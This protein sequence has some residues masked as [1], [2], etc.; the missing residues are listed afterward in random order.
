MVMRYPTRE[1][2]SDSSSLSSADQ[3]TASAARAPGWL[4][5]PGARSMCERPKTPEGSCPV[6]RGL[7]I[8]EHFSL[9]C[10]RA[11]R[12]RGY[13][14]SRRAPG[15]LAGRPPEAVTLEIVCA[16]R[17]DGALALT[18]RVRKGADVRAGHP[19]LPPPRFHPSPVAS[20]RSR[21]A[22]EASR[23]STRVS[24][25]RTRAR[26][27]GSDA[28]RSPSARRDRRQVEAA[29]E[30]EGSSRADLRAGQPAGL[31]DRREAEGG[32][33]PATPPV[34]RPPRSGPMRDRMNS[35]RTEARASSAAGRE[36]DRRHCQRHGRFLHAIGNPL[37]P[38]TANRIGA[39][40]RD[41]HGCG[42]RRPLALE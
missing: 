40:V 18:A 22:S 6:D 10:S 42:S 36:T 25:C 38:R 12:G 11:P 37:N 24:A 26:G 27:S 14:T 41:D 5:R 34:V 20:V 9:L 32:H 29:P 7:S 23:H 30:A 35:P 1:Y 4:G 21:S 33:V 13:L 8:S 16:V 17:S 2:Q 19:S 3:L 28:E 39:D 15:G 31:P